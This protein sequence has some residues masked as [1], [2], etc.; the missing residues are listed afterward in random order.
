MYDVKILKPHG[1]LWRMFLWRIGPN[2]TAQFAIGTPTLERQ[3]TGSTW[4]VPIPKSLHIPGTEPELNPAHY[5]FTT[6]EI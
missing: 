5:H 3:D 6:G 4:D 1:E 2:P